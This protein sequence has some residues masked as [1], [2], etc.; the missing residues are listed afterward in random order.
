[1]LKLLSRDWFLEIADV[2]ADIADFYVD[3]GNIYVDIAGFYVDVGG[4]YVGITGF[5]P[6]T[7]DTVAG[8]AK[9]IA[10]PATV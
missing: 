9:P 8:R 7:S 4:F 2:N 3:V 5:C 6:V 1:M 10:L